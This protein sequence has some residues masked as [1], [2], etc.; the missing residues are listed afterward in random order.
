MAGRLTPARSILS[1]SATAADCYRTISDAVA[2]AGHGDVIS[3][4]PGTYHESV[5]LE[6]EITLSAV[7][8]P[9]GVR[10]EARDAPAIRVAGESAALSGIVI[11]HSGEQTSPIDVPTGRLRMDECTVE[12]DS[13]AA[14]YA[15]GAADVIARRTVR[16]PTRPAPG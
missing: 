11:R 13:A 3:I 10:I 15:H 5:V 12:A 9:G 14:L 7:G 6:R 4:Q 2:A 1:V 16:S 8:A